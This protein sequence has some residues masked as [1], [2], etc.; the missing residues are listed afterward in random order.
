LDRPDLEVAVYGRNL[1]N[2]QYYTN[3]FDSYS[4]LAVSQGFQGNPLPTE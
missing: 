2:T 3:Q 1:T 4:S